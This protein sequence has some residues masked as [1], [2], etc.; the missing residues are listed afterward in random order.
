M[1]WIWNGAKGLIVNKDLSCANANENP[2]PGA[3]L[4]GHIRKIVG[5]V[6]SSELG[7]VISA[8]ENGPILVHTVYGDLLRQFEPANHA[9]EDPTQLY[10]LQD[11]E[12][13]CVIYQS[14]RVAFFTINGKYLNDAKI[15]DD[16]SILAVTM[17]QDGQFLV[18]GGER[19][20]VYIYR[21][22]DLALVY[23]FPACDASIRSLA[24]THDQK[25]IIVGLSTG[26]LIVFNVNFNVI[27]QRKKSITN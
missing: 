23:T 8:S 20:T 19:G 22:F 21:A 15:N 24:I 12:N 17:S 7:L 2:S 14:N 4:T 5:V 1:I 27:N 3:I 26:C 11:A 16:D 10:M 9:L 18:V 25:Y 13:V 6:V